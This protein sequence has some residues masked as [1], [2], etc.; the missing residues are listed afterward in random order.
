VPTVVGTA[1]NLLTITAVAVLPVALPVF[2]G[3]AV[4][5]GI[6]SSKGV[7]KTGVYSDGST[8]FVRGNAD[9]GAYVLHFATDE[10]RASKPYAGPPPAEAIAAVDEVM[11]GVA[12]AAGAAG[13]AAAEGAASEGAASKGA[14][15]DAANV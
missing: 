14:A 2:I 10:E 5:S 9:D 15:G 11:K 3:T 13:G 6:M 12:A 1:V 7:S 4:V 8:L